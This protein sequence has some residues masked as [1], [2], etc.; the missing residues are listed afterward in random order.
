TAGR[1]AAATWLLGEAQ[2][3]DVL[4]GY[5]PVYLEAWG[6]DADF[7]RTV[8]P[9]E[10]AKPL[11][12]GIWVFDASDTTNKDQQLEIVRRFPRPPSAFEVRAFGPYLVIR[13]REPVRTPERYVELAAAAMVA[14]KT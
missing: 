14:G 2:P 7:S 6:R 11:G 13:T 3:G 5:E 12:R 1:E 10:A 9:R 4:L 8:L